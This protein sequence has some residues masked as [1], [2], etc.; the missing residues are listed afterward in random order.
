MRIGKKTRQSSLKE[1]G[2]VGGGLLAGVLS[3][4]KG[5]PLRGGH[6]AAVCS[7]KQ[8]SG[9]TSESFPPPHHP[10]FTKTTARKVKAV[11]RLVVSDCKTMFK[12][13]TRGDGLLFPHGSALETT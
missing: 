10:R 6:A 8:P 3:V 5:I 12:R 4:V 2:G 1:G 11:M 9:V 7:G 13:A